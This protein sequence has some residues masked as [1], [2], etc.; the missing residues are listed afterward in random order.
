MSSVPIGTTFVGPNTETF[1]VTDFLGQ[2]AFGEVYRAAG[3]NSGVVVAV[4]LLP[5]GCQCLCATPIQEFPSDVVGL[6]RPVLKDL[7][8]LRQSDIQSFGSAPHDSATSRAL[9]MSFSR[10]FGS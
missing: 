10:V 1:K 4:K 7:S 9:A 3:E 5:L 6:F 2:G 8:N